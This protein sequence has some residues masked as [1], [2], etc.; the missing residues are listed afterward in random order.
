MSTCNLSAFT[1][2]FE[3]LLKEISQYEIYILEDFNIDLLK[4]SEHLLS[5]EYL[6]MLYSNNL[7]PLI[8]KP[9]R[10]TH[11]TSTLID[12]IYTNSNLSVD[13]GIALVD[14]SDHLPV[15]CILDR[16][17][18]RFRRAS[19]FRDYSNFDVDQ[20]IRDVDAVDWISVCNE[21]NDIHEEATNCISVLKQIA[22]KHASIKQASQSK[23]R[24]L[25]K[26]W[27]TK[28]VL[29]SVKHKQKL[30]KSHFLQRS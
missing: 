4:Y 10:L 28:G 2:E 3:T 20:Y 19:Y 27:L 21:S 25:A 16:Q 24:Q 12:H 1:S 18:S 26:P 29:T 15:F 11:H 6:N 23:R 22:D 30:Y 14:I 8:T 17:I 5:E 7:L 13:A 9:T